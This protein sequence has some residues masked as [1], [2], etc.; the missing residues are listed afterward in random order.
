M[1]NDTVNKGF[2]SYEDDYVWSLALHKFPWSPSGMIPEY[3]AQSKSWIPPGSEKI[4]TINIFIFPVT[5]KYML[6]VWMSW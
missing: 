6:S 3:L 2:A 4:R 5:D 1:R